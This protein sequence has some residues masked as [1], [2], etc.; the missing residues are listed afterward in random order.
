MEKINSAMAEKSSIIIY[1]YKINQCS[2]CI[3]MYIDTH[4]QNFNTC[5]YK[6]IN[7]LSIYLLSSCN[8]LQAFSLY[9]LHGHT[10]AQG[11]EICNFGISIP[12][13]REE[14]FGFYV[15]LENFSLIFKR[16]NKY[17]HLYA[18]AQE[19]YFGRSFE[20]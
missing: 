3:D 15:P 4:H 5:T 12:R 19:P 18:L 8:L 10:L 11:Y 9:V 13:S 17:M 6:I 1:K 14:L 2:L 20:I 7:I 16:N